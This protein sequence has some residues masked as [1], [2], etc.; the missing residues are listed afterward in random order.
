MTYIDDLRENAADIVNWLMVLTNHM[1][2]L[3][4]D[5]ALEAIGVVKGRMGDD[6][7]SP[8]LKDLN[9]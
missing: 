6:F 2:G 5:A 8:F 1:D 7:M 4:R 9:D 3:V